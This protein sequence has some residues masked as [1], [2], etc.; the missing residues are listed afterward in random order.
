LLG[1]AASPACH[2]RIDLIEQPGMNRLGQAALGLGRVG[3]AGRVYERIESY[4]LRDIGDWLSKAKERVALTP[5][6]EIDTT[7]LAKRDCIHP[8]DDLAHHLRQ[9]ACDKQKRSIFSTFRFH[10]ILSYPP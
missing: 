9:V 4:H 8:A 10:S 6:H 3:N 1:L 7:R 2:K 5:R